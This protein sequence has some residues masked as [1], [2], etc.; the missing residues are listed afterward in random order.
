MAVRATPEGATII[1]ASCTE[2]V[3]RRS[4]CPR[5]GTSTALEGRY[6]L[7]EAI[8]AGSFG[9]TYRAAR[10][11]DRYP[12]A[13][14]EMLVRRADSVKVMDLFAREARVLEQL[15]HPGIPRYFEDF[16]HDAGRSTAFFLVQELIDGEPLHR[17]FD[18]RFVRVD[19]VFRM[20]AELLDT[21]VYLHGFSPPV[22]HRDI[23]PANVMRRSSDG[24]LVLIDFGSVRAAL[25]VDDDGSTV[26]GT[27]GFM[28]PEQFAGRATARS[29]VYGV[30]A[31]A[32]A[33]LSGRE[34]HELMGSGR[35]I[36][37]DRL[38][39]EAVYADV[40]RA[41][42][43]AAP[44]RRPTAREA[45]AAIRRVL[46]GDPSGLA[47]APSLQRPPS[48]RAQHPIGHGLVPSRLAIPPPPRGI[49][50]DLLKVYAAG[51][52]FRLLFGALFGGLGGGIPF[53][54]MIA[55]IASG[56]PEAALFLVIFVLVFGGIGGVTF[57]RGLKQRTSVHRVWREGVE[58]TGVCTGQS[59][60]SYAVNNQRAH[61]YRYTFEVDGRSYSGRW[62]TWSPVPIFEGHEVQVLYLPDDPS[63]N[64]MVARL[65]ATR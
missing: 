10:L 4:T 34:P 7:L 61:V 38:E 21:L 40:L 31:T 54:I 65:P 14:K 57:A 46:A 41:M 9:T 20:M 37:V 29:D 23:K 32:V 1:C 60:S 8:G 55:M 58:A 51:A 33:L 2:Q 27:F 59:L 5:C 48:L 64:L 49:P 50:S 13:I 3:P 22:I 16:V 56:I 45:A 15:E 17:V 39:L 47:P 11:T 42:L 6:E 12:V 44:D 25:S 24:S 63:E 28:A 26:A 52:N 36:D 30:A 35:E 53:I 62:D 19:E 43:A 18:G